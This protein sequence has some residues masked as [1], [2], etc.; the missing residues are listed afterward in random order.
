M[1]DCLHGP[2]QNLENAA[3]QVHHI[4]YGGHGI[5]GEVSIA[6]LMRK[7][8]PPPE[9]LIEGVILAAKVTSL[10]GGPGT[11]KTFIAL[12]LALQVIRGGGK[13]LYLDNENGA[14]LITERM[15]ALDATPEELEASFTYHAFPALSVG[16]TDV[17]GYIEAVDAGDYSLV[18]SDSLANFLASFG[19]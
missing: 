17:Q 11:G 1:V 16:E 9:E 5:S 7:G 12:W 15:A 10:Y 14:R 13:V 3:A 8:I 2:V 18:I 4:G 6:D 19:V